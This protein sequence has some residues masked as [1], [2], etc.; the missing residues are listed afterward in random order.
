MRALLALFVRSMREDA[1]ARLPPILR[2]TLVLVILLI[3]WANERDF[4][5]GAPHR[6]V[7]SSAGCSLPMS[8]SIAESPRPPPPAAAAAE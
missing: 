4:T 1:R 3:L 7:N 2:A 5:R 8:A 6:A